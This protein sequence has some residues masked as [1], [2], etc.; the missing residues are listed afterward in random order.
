M[1]MYDRYGAG[2]DANAQERYIPGAGGMGATNR[3]RE[4]IAE[5]GYLPYAQQQYTQ[6]QA[7]VDQSNLDRQDKERN[8]ELLFGDPDRRGP[9]PSREG[10]ES[11]GSAGGFDL[12]KLLAL[13]TGAT[14]SEDVQI[15]DM[16]KSTTG[17]LPT[18]TDFIRG[19]FDT[20]S[21]EKIGMDANSTNRY[22]ADKGLEGI[23]STNQNRID[24][25][26]QQ[27]ARQR[28]REGLFSQ[29]TGQMGRPVFPVPAAATE[30]S[31]PDWQGLS[32]LMSSGSIPKFRPGH[33]M[34]TPVG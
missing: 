2:V 20:A 5:P 27:D 16:R 25:Q 22:Q 15:G 32:S 26:T 19:L 30:A 18:F 12:S 6:P 31:K 3:G 29:F 24:L 13:L 7:Y 23:N 8:K 21:R 28:E 10:G 4:V 11:G 14:T 34:P 17:T 33:R 9:V 1:G